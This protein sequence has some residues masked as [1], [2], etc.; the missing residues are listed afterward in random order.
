M[1]FTGGSFEFARFAAD[2]NTPLN[3]EHTM[4]FRLNAAGQTG[5]ALSRTRDMLKII[6]L[7]R[8]SLPGERPVEVPGGDVDITVQGNFATGTYAVND[9]KK[10]D[11]QKF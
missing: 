8:V 1:S 4:L 3:D 11:G 5:E 2:I 10:C 7:H 6:R 9:S